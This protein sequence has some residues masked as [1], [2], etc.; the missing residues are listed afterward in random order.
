MISIHQRS[1]DQI[2]EYIKL[3][4]MITSDPKSKLKMIPTNT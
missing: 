4:N 2:T 1:V 3:N